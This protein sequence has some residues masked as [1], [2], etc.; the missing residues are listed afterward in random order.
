MFIKVF[1]L[2]RPGSGKTT[3]FRYMHQ[4]LNSLAT[5]EKPWSITWLSDYDILYDWFLKD[6]EHRYFQVADHGGFDVKDLTILDGAL[7]ELEERT[8]QYCE[9]AH[10]YEIVIVEFARDDYQKA[11]NNFSQNFLDTTHALFLDANIEICIDRVEKRVLNGISID[12]HFLSPD[13]ILSILW[14]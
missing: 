10:D 14:I 9:C 12:N 11:L 2:G 1:V 4:L 13:M 3:A 5:S 6:K 8:E 7:K